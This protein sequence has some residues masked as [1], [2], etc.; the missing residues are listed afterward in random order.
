MATVHTKTAAV[1]AAI[2]SSATD[3]NQ[4]AHDILEA[5]GAVIPVIASNISLANGN[6][7]GHR[8]LAC[9][10]YERHVE[11]RLNSNSFSSEVR[12]LGLYD[13]RRP[14]RMRDIPEGPKSIDSVREFLYSAGYEE[15][16]TTP[17]FSSENRYVGLL[18]LS[19]DDADHPT[20]EARHLLEILAPSIA[21][22][23][24]P[25]ADIELLMRPLS[26]Q[27]SAALIG[28]D[29]RAHSADGWHRWP[30]SGRRPL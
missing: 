8:S 27:A 2:A 16:M 29:G 14:I 28:A 6:V 26:D 1:V 18:N 13:H 24:D 15:G 5:L 17:L 12:A 23:V 20:D 7:G 30:P 11:A 25:V 4:R 21:N 19:T 3:P 22:A 9:H 10:D